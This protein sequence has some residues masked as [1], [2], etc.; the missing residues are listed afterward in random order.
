MIAFTFIFSILF[1]VFF[2]FY[3]QA[4]QWMHDHNMKVREREREREN[5]VKRMSQRERD[6]KER[7]EKL[8]CVYTEEWD[9]RSLWEGKKEILRGIEKDC[10]IIYVCVREIVAE[11]NRA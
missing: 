7:V 3:M 1:F 6:K 4:M 9:N 2:H 8:N 10:G 5:E 11:R